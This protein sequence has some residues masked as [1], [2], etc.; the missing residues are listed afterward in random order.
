[1]RRAFGAGVQ[2]YLPWKGDGITH[3]SPSTSPWG[4]FRGEAL[5]WL[6]LLLLLLCEEFLD[7]LKKFHS[8]LPSFLS[9]DIFTMVNR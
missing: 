5:L 6:L 1:M 2:L 4:S 7:T 9:R 3:S 8:Q